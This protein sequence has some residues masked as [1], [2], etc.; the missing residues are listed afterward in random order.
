MATCCERTVPLAFHLCFKFSTV[1]V[2]RVL[3]PF[4]VW[5]RMCNSIVSVPDHCLFIYFSSLT[6]TRSNLFTFFLLSVTFF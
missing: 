4:G 6:K 2:V 1:L 5:D 3:F